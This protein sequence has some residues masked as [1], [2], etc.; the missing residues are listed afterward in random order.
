MNPHLKRPM[1]PKQLE[2]ERYFA[3]RYCARNNAFVRDA[4]NLAPELG[5]SELA[6]LEMHCRDAAEELRAA[7]RREP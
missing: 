5:D 4:R 2:A 7:W 1:T 3:E 6:E